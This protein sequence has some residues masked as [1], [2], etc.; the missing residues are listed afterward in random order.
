MLE[1]SNGHRTKPEINLNDPAFT[2]T[3]T[4]SSFKR[5]NDNYTTSIK[6][7]G[8]ASLCNFQLSP[9][10]S[11]GSTNSAFNYTNNG[12]NTNTTEKA[13]KDLNSINRI[14]NLNNIANTSIKKTHRTETQF[15]NKFQSKLNNLGNLIG[16]NNNSLRKEVNIQNLLDGRKT[17]KKKDLIEN[18]NSFTNTLNTEIIATEHTNLRKSS[19]KFI[20]N[21]DNNQ[22]LSS[23]DFY[24]KLTEDCA[25]A[26]TRNKDNRECR[27]LKEIDLFS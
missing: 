25:S 17:N 13:D 4:Q 23:Q 11:I 15:D 21:R 20:L 6:D 3:L 27:L 18:I 26:R 22:Q 10:A 7:L 8:K 14:A 1:L 9:S 16:L 2:T 24:S 12:I 19:P 5:F